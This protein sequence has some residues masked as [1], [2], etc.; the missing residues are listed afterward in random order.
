MTEETNKPVQRHDR[1]LGTCVQDTHDETVRNIKEYLKRP[2]LAK[3]A[4]GAIPLHGDALRRYADL[5]AIKEHEYAKL[6]REY[7]EAKKS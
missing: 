2:I 1:D 3:E 6:V 7:R 5:G 4:N